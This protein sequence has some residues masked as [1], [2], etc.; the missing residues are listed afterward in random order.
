MREIK[1]R[2]WDEQNKVMH[3]DFQFIKSGDR[4]NDWIVF[5]SDKQDY[6]NRCL[7]NPYFS[8][9]LKIMQFVGIKDINDK[10]I[11]EHDIIQSYDSEGNKIKHAV[12]YDPDLCRWNLHK[13]WVDKFKK[14]VVGNIYENPELLI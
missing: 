9:Q 12:T 1:F 13:D 5:N 14:E 2:G 11:Y 8:Q 3:H 6:I 7:D 4:G 10:E